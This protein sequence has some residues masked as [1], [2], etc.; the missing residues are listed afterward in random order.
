[1][2]YKSN[3]FETWKEL[4]TVDLHSYPLMLQYKGIFEGRQRG[5]LPL[6]LRPTLGPFKFL[7]MYYRCS[8]VVLDKKANSRVNE[9]QYTLL[10]MKLAFM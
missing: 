8:Y 7:M 3:C 1:M 9:T 5:A 2:T 4:P 6:V 10:L